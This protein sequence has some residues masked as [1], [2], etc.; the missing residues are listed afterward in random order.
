MVG[1]SRI[2]SASSFFHLNI[3]S[4]SLSGSQQLSSRDN[5]RQEL[6][7]LH[8]LPMD[9]PT[10]PRSPVCPTKNDH[11]LN[12]STHLP[13]HLHDRVRITSIPSWRLLMLPHHQARLPWLMSTRFTRWLLS[14]LIDKLMRL[15]FPIGLIQ[16]LAPTRTTLLRSI[17]APADVNRLT[18]VCEILH[19]NG[20]LPSADLWHLV[21]ADR[22]AIQAYQEN[23]SVKAIA[24]C[25]DPFHPTQTRPTTDSW[26]WCDHQLRET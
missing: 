9:P 19:V 3:Y 21:H 7:R 1:F 6:E 25:L 2:C 26:A 24:S 22:F 8:T 23:S 5:P 13:Q 11:H 15:S 18:R 17:L 16:A 14:A 4:F 20:C 12:S 10:N